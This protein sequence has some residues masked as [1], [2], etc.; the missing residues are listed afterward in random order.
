MA[1][2]TLEHPGVVFPP[3]L[4]YFLGFGFG[5]LLHRAWPL[6]VVL[7]GPTPMTLTAGWVCVALGLAFMLWGAA[8]F[9]RHRTAI[10]P[11]RPA[12]RLVTVGP[13][14]YSRNPMYVGLTA[15]YVGLILLANILWPFVLLPLV[16]LALTYAVIQRE[17]RYLSGAFDSEYRAYSARVRRWM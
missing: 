10:L 17:E 8:T 13:Y 11:M 16:L 14:R 6:H 5:W 12:A 2:G 3:P 9:F 4:L 7:G 15:A 1:K